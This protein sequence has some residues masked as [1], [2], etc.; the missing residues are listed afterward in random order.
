MRLTAGVIS[1]I[2]TCLLVMPATAYNGSQLARAPVEDFSLITQD[3]AAYELER[4]NESVMVVSFIFT[5]CPDVCPVITQLLSSVQNEL[6]DEQAEDVQFVSITVDP[7]YDTPER[8]LDYTQ[9]HGVDWPHLT[10]ER[11]LLENVWSNFALV[12]Q[13]QVIDAHVMDYQPGE[14]SVTVVN[15]NNTT[16]QSMFTWNGYTATTWAAEELGLSLNVSD[17]E[18]GHFL[19]GIN[20]TDSPSDRSWYWELNVWNASNSTWEASPVGMDTLDVLDHPHIAWKPSYANAS[21]IPQPANTTVSTVTVQWS[22]STVQTAEITQFTGHHVTHGALSGAGINVTMPDSSLGH[23]MTSIA[24]QSG[25]D[26][27]SWWWNLYA[28]NDTDSNWTSSEVGMDGLLQP[29]HL[30]WAPSNVNVSEI[31]SPIQPADSTA[32]D[33]HGWEMGSGAGLHCMC[34]AGYTWDGEDR[35]SCVPEATEEYNVGHSTITYILNERRQPI[36]AW[37]G[38]RWGVDAFTEDV[39]EVLRSEN[40]GGFEDNDTPWPS[41]ALTLAG[42]MAA[43]VLSPNQRNPRSSEEERKG[44]K[45]GTTPLT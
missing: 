34:D 20:G 1:I 27:F 11:E 16:S 8:L 18:F 30:A 29:H 36:V 37:T 25:P 38:D 41:A 5:R 21:M 39:R 14:A 42:L 4:Q 9:R 24:N 35:R 45:E 43:A 7:E 44:E 15:T 12:V 32:C 10:G 23:Y 26:D 31:P 13:Q 6:T 40:A 19:S 2:L 17:S 33:G 3:G 28:W 22:N